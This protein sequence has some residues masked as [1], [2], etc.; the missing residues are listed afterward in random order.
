MPGGEL[1]PEG[2]ETSLPHCQAL[3]LQL[4]LIMDLAHRPDSPETPQ[5]S[6]I[7]ARGLL[8]ES[9]ASRGQSTPQ[10]LVSKLQSPSAIYCLRQFSKRQN[11]TPAV[12]QPIPCSL[13]LCPD[14]LLQQQ[15][16][17]QHQPHTSCCKPPPSREACPCLPLHSCTKAS[18]KPSLASER[19][20]GIWGDLV[21]RCM[22]CTQTQRCSLQVTSC[23][24]PSSSS[25]T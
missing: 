15:E 6:D 5:N 18:L 1:C 7:T 4:F 23:Q 22:P 8:E 3:S 11:C 20:R 19:L 14:D 12:P 16:L 17:E 9:Q 24:T 21:T 25:C 13:G 10:N 2:R